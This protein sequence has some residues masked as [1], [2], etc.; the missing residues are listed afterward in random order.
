[1]LLPG[2]R[3]GAANHLASA[4]STARIR[5]IRRIGRWQQIPPSGV[6]GWG[7]GAG[8]DWMMGVGGHHPA[9]PADGGQRGADVAPGG[10]SD[11]WL[12]RATVLGEPCGNRTGIRH[13]L[14]GR[15]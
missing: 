1:V 7:Y 14:N 8:D 5:G 13:K 3:R 9:A 10:E 15:F 2:L 4:A 12:K 6:L 11:K